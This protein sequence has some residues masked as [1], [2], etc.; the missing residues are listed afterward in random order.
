[1]LIHSNNELVVK[2]QDY[3]REN[4]DLIFFSPYIKINALE[5]LLVGQV[6]KVKTI[7]TSWKSHDIL[8]G[9]SDLEVYK[10]CNDHGIQLLINQNIHLKAIT[11]NN[12]SSCIVSSANL[13]NRGLALSKKHNIE[14]GT[15]VDKLDLNDQC[16]FDRIIDSSILITDDLY[17]TIKKQIDEIIIVPQYD[18]SITCLDDLL[19]IDNYYLN[20]DKFLTSQL[21]Y[22]NNPEDLYH[23]I[24][25]QK[26]YDTSEIRSAF[27]DIQL[28]KVQESNDKRDFEKTLKTNFLKNHFINDFLLYNGEGNYFGKNTSWI[29]SKI[30]DVPA[31]KRWGIK[32]YQQRIY[33]Y[34]E[35]LL[36]DMYRIERPRYSQ[37]LRRINN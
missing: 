23:V 37:L 32:E 26:H 34:I 13:T 31:P 11:N 7:V 5:Q 4:E 27:H 29:H 30:Q 15:I 25:N 21:P 35:L 2:Y 16:Y 1:M 10:Y 22:F 18:T 17:N 14:L 28:Y 19:S 33:S 9:S 12:M 20:N 36:S 3:I 8:H 6:T 24:T